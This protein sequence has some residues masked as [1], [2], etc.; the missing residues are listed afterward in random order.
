[1][2]VNHEQAHLALRNRLLTVA[3][4]P[5]VNA[6][7]NKKFSATPGTPYLADQYV[8]A[9]SRNLSFPANTG[10]TEETGLYVIQWYGIDDTGIGAIRTGVQAILAAFAPGTALT[11]TTG[12]VIRVRSDVGPF[13][14]QIIPLDSGFACCTVKIPW[15]ARSTNVIA[16]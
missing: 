10:T 2:A 8:P 13:G 5:S 11:S 12:D 3:G 4:I 9:T 15:R 1:M 7:E 6:W 14:G 16:A